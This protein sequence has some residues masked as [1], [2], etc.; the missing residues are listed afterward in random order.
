MYWILKIILGWAIKLVWIKKVEG[1][2]NIPKSGA[3]IIAANH[4]SYKEVYQKAFSILNS[5]KVLGIFPEGTRS[6]D[7]KIG[8]TY[9]GLRDSP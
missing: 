9:T 7:G 1:V 2:E 3:C 6:P 4:N 5:G 8:K